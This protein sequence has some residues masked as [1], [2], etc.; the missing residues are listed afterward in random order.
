MM[1]V[2][3]RA[4]AV[5]IGLKVGTMLDA[6]QLDWLYWLARQAPDGPAVE[7]GVWKGGSIVCWGR[8][9]KERG[10]LHAVDNFYAHLE[11]RPGA[12]KVRATFKRNAKAS[13]LDITLW[14]QMGHEAAANFE[15]VSVA[16]CFIDADHGEEGITKDLPAWVPKIKPGGVLVCHDYATWKCPAVERTV[17]EWHAAEKWERLGLVGSAIAFRRPVTEENTPDADCTEASL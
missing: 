6:P 16:F 9:R 2:N 3:M 8:A 10:P 13:G 4:A 15:D 17:D 7:V 14:E 1:P 11:E 5:A 12:D